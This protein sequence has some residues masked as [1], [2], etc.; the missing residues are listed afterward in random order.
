[1]AHAT[2]VEVRPLATHADFREAV[3]VQRSI[4]GFSDIDLVPH[5]VLSTASQNGGVVLGAFQGSTML[6]VVFGFPG[7]TPQGTVKHCSHIMGVVAA[8]RGR[9]VGSALKWAQ[10]DMVLGQGIDLATWTFDPLE[11]RNASLN[12][13]HLGAIS[14]E[15]LEDVY[16]DLDDELNRGSPT[17]R[18]A[19]E[20]W[21][22]SERVR[23]R[24]STRAA[25]ARTAAEAGPAM[26]ATT[27]SRDGTRI[28]ERW[29]VPVTETARLELPA[30]LQA[31]KARDPELARSWR[32]FVRDAL[33]GAFAHG[34]V[35]ADVVRGDGSDGRGRFY[36]CLEHRSVL[37]VR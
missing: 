13:R 33:Q 16:G 37:A 8:G 26:S 28:P 27:A 21:L 29:E 3:A 34:F 10:R 9:G 7:L 35:A 15:Y 17:D 31:L 25:A 22:A 32:F 20:W 24:R 23:S 1:M 2:G 6:G 11:A 4:W 5:H 18:L 36:Y 12:L 30:S 14:A 19:V